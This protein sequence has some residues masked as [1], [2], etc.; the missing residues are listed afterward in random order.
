[1]FFSTIPGQ[2]IIYLINSCFLGW[3]GTTNIHQPDSLR[4]NVCLWVGGHRRSIINQ[5]V[6]LSFT[7][8]GKLG[9]GMGNWI[10]VPIMVGECRIMMVDDLG[11]PALL[12]VIPHDQSL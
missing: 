12:V 3:V 10:F 5:N 9:E 1:M 6:K 7:S 4:V 11:Y 8:Y 2:M